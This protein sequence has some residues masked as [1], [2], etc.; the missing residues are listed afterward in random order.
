MTGSPQ[1]HAPVRFVWRVGEDILGMTFAL[2][3]SLGPQDEGFFGF[4]LS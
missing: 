4:E 2:A 3:Q 1:N